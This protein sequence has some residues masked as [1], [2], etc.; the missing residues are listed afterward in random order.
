MKPHARICIWE[1]GRGWTLLYG[2]RTSRKTSERCKPGESHNIDDLRTFPY[3]LYFHLKFLSLSLQPS[4]CHHV[5][6]SLVHFDN[7]TLILSISRTDNQWG[8]SKT[9]A[10]QASY[11]TSI[12]PALE[13]ERERDPRSFG[14]LG[15]LQVPPSRTNESHQSIQAYVSEQWIV[16]F[17]YISDLYY[18]QCPLITYRRTKTYH[19]T[20]ILKKG[21]HIIGSFVR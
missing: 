4:H 10:F 5:S 15:R 17:C 12:Y 13:G 7:H 3:L 6:S 20:W 11:F 21:L 2:T 19:G 16:Y 14:D 1:T 9:A 18:N 8:C